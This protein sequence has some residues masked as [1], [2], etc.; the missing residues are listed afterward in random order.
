MTFLLDTNVLLRWSDSASPLHATCTE[1]VS[2][3]T[4]QSHVLC[5]CAQVL[6]E[7]Y[8]VATRPLKD[9][10]LGFAPEQGRQLI[11]DLKQS[12][13]C[14]PEPHDIADRWEAVIT[15]HSVSGRQG[16][17]AR[18]AAL[19][20]ANGVNNLITLN[21]SDFARYGGLTAM[22]PSDALAI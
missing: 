20:M 10:G 14:L 21:T 5:V 4:R 1:A 15:Q 18:I 12:F 19:M 13:P 7:S 11:A 3:L 22:T 6:I 16:H 9:N 8:V 2:S 17:D